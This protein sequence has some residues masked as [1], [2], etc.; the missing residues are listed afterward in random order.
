MHLIIYGPEGSGK[1]TQAKLIAEKLNL[2]VITSGD[3]VREKAKENNEL[4]R[5]CK[6]SL[7]Q[8][9]YVP[10]E[11]MFKLWEEKLSSSDILKG[12]I[13]DG[14]P[15]SINQTKFL[16]DALNKLNLKIDKFIYLKLS[17]DQARKRLLKRKRK[18]FEGS[19]ISHDTPQRIRERLKIY[20][21]K[22]TPIVDFFK[23]NNLLMEIDAGKSV[24]LVSKSII[25]K[26]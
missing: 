19:N 3:L 16:I 10:D 1:G 26:I 18:I 21:K 15:R 11:I 6:S 25:E 24:N 7:T 14:F 22:E 23:K 5:I 8:G 20:R 2:P 12:F 17:D 9:K 4:G 13:L